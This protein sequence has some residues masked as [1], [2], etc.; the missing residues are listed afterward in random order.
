M[1]K[2]LVY[3]GKLKFQ[4]ICQKCAKKDFY[5]DV[6]ILGFRGVFGS[7]PYQKEKFEPP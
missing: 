3:P 1:M 4:R 2:K 7:F 6:Y 5:Q